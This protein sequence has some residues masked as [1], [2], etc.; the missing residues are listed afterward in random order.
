[1]ANILN[2][3][4]GVAVIGDGLEEGTSGFARG[5][6]AFPVVP[7]VAAVF[8]VI[9][10]LK[11]NCGKA[12]TIASER[13]SSLAVLCFPIFAVRQ[14]DTDVKITVIASNDCFWSFVASFPIFWRSECFG[15]GIF[16]IFQF[17]GIV[18]NC[19]IKVVGNSAADSEEN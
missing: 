17:E 19:S 16:A 18:E 14:T 11:V 2:W 4:T 10:I 3:I 7:A 13:Q 9:F 6:F 15:R 5:K 12:N 1:M 8:P